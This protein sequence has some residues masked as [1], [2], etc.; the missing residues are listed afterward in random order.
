LGG[1][2]LVGR[3]LDRLSSVVLPAVGSHTRRGQPLCWLVDDSVPIPFASPVTGTVVRVNP[4]IRA[5]PT[6][7]LHSPY[8]EGWLLE[9]A[10][11]PGLLQR[12][13][14]LNGPAEQR[15]VSARQLRDL[16]RRGT[17][18]EERIRASVGPT[19]C[20]GGLPVRGMRRRLG[21][22]DYHRLVSRLLR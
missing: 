8:G 17:R 7:I 10:A 22:R 3:L 14:D 11:Q 4:R 9:L 15:G 20:D 13:K 19:L 1:D 16:H 6:P 12:R 2:A 5:D 21:T 18:L